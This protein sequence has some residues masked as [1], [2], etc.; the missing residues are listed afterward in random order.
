MNEDSDQQFQGS[1][2]DDPV[3]SK[4]LK[5]IEK[6]F[7]ALGIKKGDPRWKTLGFELLKR[8]VSEWPRAYQRLLLGPSG[9]PPPEIP[10]SQ[11]RG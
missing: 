2:M 1:Y 4:H 10:P 3:V 5:S 11:G 8:S 7:G 6:V 9:P